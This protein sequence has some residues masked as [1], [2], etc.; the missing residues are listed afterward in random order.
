MSVQQ[1]GHGFHKGKADVIQDILKGMRPPDQFHAAVHMKQAG[2]KYC[3]F[4]CPICG[5]IALYKM[6]GCSGW[7]DS[8]GAFFQNFE[9]VHKLTPEKGMLYPDAL[10]FLEVQTA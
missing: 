10:G 7:C 1:W 4:E 3:D 2:G 8:C 6:S 9:P 5:K